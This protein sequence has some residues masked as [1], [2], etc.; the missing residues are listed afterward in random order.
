[1]GHRNVGRAAGFLMSSCGYSPQLKS[2]VD[3]WLVPQRSAGIGPQTNS[4]VATV[5]LHV[6]ADISSSFV[7]L[8]GHSVQ[9]GLRVCPPIG[10][11]ATEAIFST[12]LANSPSLE[13][14]ASIQAW[15]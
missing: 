5:Y 6:S 1:M 13:I 9:R 14:D 8:P 12:R 4:Y 3:R 15:S 7:P 10:Q 2:G 11:T